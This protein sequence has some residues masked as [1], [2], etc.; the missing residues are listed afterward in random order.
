[1]GYCTA[2]EVASDFKNINFNASSSVTQSEVEAFIDQESAFVNDMISNKYKTPVGSSESPNSY[3][4]LKRI[5]IALVADRVRHV[6]EV[7]TGRELNDQETKGHIS[8][9]RDPQKDLR[10]IRDGKMRLLDAVPIDNVGFDSG[11][12]SEDDCDTTFKVDGEQW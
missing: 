5:T 9:S 6:I 7:K 8:M 2:S 12:I 11:L 3:L 10:A 4:T 1:M